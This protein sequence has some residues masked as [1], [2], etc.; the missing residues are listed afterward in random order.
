MFG[1]N[2]YL[3]TCMID[4]ILLIT[5]EKQEYYSTNIYNR[6]SYFILLSGIF[7][8]L[9]FVTIAIIFQELFV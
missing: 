2:V 8:H 6:Y 1:I 7:E 9:A 3:F 4:F 5:F